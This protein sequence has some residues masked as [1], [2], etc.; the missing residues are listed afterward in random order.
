VDFDAAVKIAFDYADKHPGTLVVA[1]ADHETG[2][3]TI[4]NNNNRFDVNENPIAYHFATGGHSGGMVPIFAY[5]AGA[6]AFSRVLENTDIP[7]I[8]KS[9]LAE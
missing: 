2:G 7:L 8:M 9:L 6:D 4:I 1:T 5:G 3:L